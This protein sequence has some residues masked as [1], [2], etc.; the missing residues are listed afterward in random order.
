MLSLLRCVAAHAPDW[1]A[2]RRGAQAGWSYTDTLGY[3]DR[4]R[5]ALLAPDDARTSA[6]ELFRTYATARHECD[7]LPY[8]RC[9]RICPD[10]TCLY[11]GAVADIVEAGRYEATWSQADDS[12]RADG[13]RDATWHACDLAAYELLEYPPDDATPEQIAQINDSRR[14]AGLCFAQQMLAADSNELPRSSRSIIDNLPT[15]STGEG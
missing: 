7:V 8:P 10:H 9:D 11:H 3:A 5:S 12:D 14:R 6:V 15:T 2:A 4:L 1:Y 13:T